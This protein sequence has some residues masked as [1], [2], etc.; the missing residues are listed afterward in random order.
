MPGSTAWVHQMVVQMLRLKV[1][2]HS[3]VA[4]FHRVFNFVELAGVDVIIVH[5]LLKNSVEADQYLL[6]SEAARTDLEF[7]TPLE[8]ESGRE[9]YEDIGPVSTLIFRPD[10][11][12]FAT[13]PA[14]PSRGE[15]LQRAWR[16]YCQL[17]FA[18]FARRSAPFRHVESGSHRLTRPVFA[19]FTALFTPLFLPVG[20]I[21]VLIHAF[22]EPAKITHTGPA[23]VHKADGSCC[24]HHHHD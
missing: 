21:F 2:V 10:H 14:V 3:G 4:L 6:L 1:V 18:P 22:K 12:P 23:H 5:R 13:P 20:A 11:H 16:M 15:R 9:T 8:W 7:S 19:A 17:W 24:Q